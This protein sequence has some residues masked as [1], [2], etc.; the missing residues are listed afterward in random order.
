M[1]GLVA[2]ASCSPAT[3][4]AFNDSEQK[5]TASLRA[6]SLDYCGL[7]LHTVLAIRA[8]VTLRNQGTPGTLV[9]GAQGIFYFAVE[10]RNGSGVLATTET[11]VTLL[12]DPEEA[13]VPVTPDDLIRLGHGQA[14]SFEATLHVPV[15]GIR[16]EKCPG[17]SRNAN[18]LRRL[19]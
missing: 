1:L 7:P 2:L 11:G 6:L 9:R 14:H 8:Q 3:T 5:L 12:S 15:T 18:C 17:K 16:I 4:V 13:G 19:S 10:Y